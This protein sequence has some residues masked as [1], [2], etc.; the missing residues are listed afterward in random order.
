MIKIFK[1]KSTKLEFKLNVVG[2]TD[3]PTVRLVLPNSESLSTV[4]TATVEGDSAKII[5]PP[6]KDFG[7]SFKI[8]DKAVLEVIVDNCYFIPWTKSI[9]VAES[10]TVSAALVKE[11]AQDQVITVDATIIKKPVAIEQSEPKSADGRGDG[12][13]EQYDSFTKALA[14]RTNRKRVSGRH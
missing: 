8:S 9:E 7:K 10:V 2:S 13:Q 1:D 14:K 11:E 3:V 4:I 5:V 6:L 12:F